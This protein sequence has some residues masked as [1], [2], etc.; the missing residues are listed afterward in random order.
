MVRDFSAW[1]ASRWA[2]VR[3]PGE[4]GGGCRSD[5]KLTNRRVFCQVPSAEA[6]ARR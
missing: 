5:R 3:S 6:R 4:D 1:K 2:A